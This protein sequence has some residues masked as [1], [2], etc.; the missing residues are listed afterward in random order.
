[1]LTLEHLRDLRDRR[2]R[3]DAARQMSRE[4]RFQAA[5]VGS[6]SMI[7]VTLVTSRKGGGEEGVAGANC[8][9]DRENKLSPVE[10]TILLPR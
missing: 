8:A 5:T 1:M 7:L 9:R 10:A 3:Y 4:M 6:Y 2:A